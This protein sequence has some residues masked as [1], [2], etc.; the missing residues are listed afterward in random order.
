MRV[1]K[2]TYI[3]IRRAK[4]FRWVLPY[5]ALAVFI[6]TQEEEASFF[7]LTYCLFLGIILSSL[8]LYGYRDAENGFLKML[9]GKPGDEIKAHFLFGFGMIALCTACGVLAT[10]MANLIHPI[11]GQMEV[12]FHYG[13]LPILSGCALLVVG[14]ED[15]LLCVFRE[16]GMRV[17][18]L[19]RIVPGFLFLFSAAYLTDAEKM[20]QAVITAA[21]VFVRQHSILIGFACVVIYI[22]IAAV[23]SAI[24]VRQD[25]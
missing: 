11:S 7:G 16:E 10:V 14:I 2:F 5:L 20:P 23:A 25:G 17:I 3:D 15:T 9:P 13:M 1:L 24:S 6:T 8:P 21:S 4:P 12:F 22:G 18:Q 19:I